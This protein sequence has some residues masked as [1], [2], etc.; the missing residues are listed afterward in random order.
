MYDFDF[1]SIERGR[2]AARPGSKT[3]KV[4]HFSQVYMVVLNYLPFLTG[5]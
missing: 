5:A 3:K 1:C 2:A 4:Y